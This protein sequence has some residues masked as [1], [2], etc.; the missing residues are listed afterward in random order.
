MYLNTAKK[1]KRN[2]YLSGKSNYHS[3]FWAR[4]RQRWLPLIATAIACALCNIGTVWTKFIEY[5][6]HKDTGHWNY[7]HRENEIRG[8]QADEFYTCDLETEI[9]YQ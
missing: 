8:T 7:R 2:Q 1:S 5:F 4:C 3:V 9:N 6:P